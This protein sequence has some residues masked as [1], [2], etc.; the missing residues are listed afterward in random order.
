[1]IF[2]IGLD[3]TDAGDVFGSATGDVGRSA[4]KLKKLLQD[5]QESFTVIEKCRVPV[6]A[7]VHGACVGGGEW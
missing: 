5:Y 2:Y 6:I 1:M 3:L 7:A 4:L